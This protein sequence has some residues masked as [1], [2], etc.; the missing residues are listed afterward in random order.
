MN[1]WRAELEQH[2]VAVGDV[3]E[4][5]WGVELTRLSVFWPPDCRNNQGGSFEEDRTHEAIH[6]IVRIGS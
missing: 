4:G 6:H 5:A 1:D 3:I 2:G